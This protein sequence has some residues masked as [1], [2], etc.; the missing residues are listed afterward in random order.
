M[1]I[2]WIRTSNVAAGILLVMRVYL[3]WLWLSAGF[4]KVTT[5]GGWSA[6]GFLQNAAANPVTKNGVPAYEWYTSFLESFAIPNA[7]LFSFLVSYGEV[8]VGLG[9]ILGCLTTWAAFFGMVMNFAFLLAGTVSHNPTDIISEIFICVAGVNAGK[10][11]L[12]YYVMPYLRNLI[13]KD[14]SQSV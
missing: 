3:G 9:L 12:D 8:L 5:E 4:G 7:K 1:I 6:A 13:I 2:K 14:K 11:G 10:F